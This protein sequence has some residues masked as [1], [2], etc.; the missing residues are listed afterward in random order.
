MATCSELG[1]LDACWVH[2]CTS[3]HH[4]E[5]CYGRGRL[6]AE[7]LAV[8]E[9]RMLYLTWSIE[10]QLNEGRSIRCSQMMGHVRIEAG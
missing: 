1:R 7:G 2:C 3:I 8:T 9:F 6:G 5:L 10:D 4:G